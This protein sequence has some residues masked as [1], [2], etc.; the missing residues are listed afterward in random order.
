MV[1]KTTNAF[2][3]VAAICL[4]WEVPKALSSNNM[5]TVTCASAYTE[6]LTTFM[7]HHPTNFLH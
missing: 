6:A 4:D 7:L 1:P 3:T 2:L 5:P